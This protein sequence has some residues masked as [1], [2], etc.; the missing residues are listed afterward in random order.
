M[1]ISPTRC[2]ISRAKIGPRVH[3]GVEL[4]VL[5][6]RVDPLGQTPQ[7]RVVKLP[8]GELLLD[9][10]LTVGYVSFDCLALEFRLAAPR[11]IKANPAKAGGTKPRVLA[12]SATSS[13]RHEGLHDRRAAERVARRPCGRTFCSTEEAR[14]VTKWLPDRFA[15]GS[16]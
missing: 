4:A 8:A 12:S 2:G 15:R 16:S 9:A 1:T 7:Q 6:A 3:E 11:R 10:P 14:R 13:W 5:T